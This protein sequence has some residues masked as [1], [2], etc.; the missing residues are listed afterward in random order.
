MDIDTTEG[1][2]IGFGIDADGDCVHGR[3]TATGR[4]IETGGLVQ[5]G[6]CLALRGR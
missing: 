5:D 6:G 2:G 4:D 1:P 3:V